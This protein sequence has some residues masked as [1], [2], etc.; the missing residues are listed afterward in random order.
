M[1]KNHWMNQNTNILIVDDN[2]PF[3]RTLKETIADSGYAAE[4]ALCG[5]EAIEQQKKNCYDLVFVDI[6]LPDMSGH[7]VVN[8]MTEICSTTEFI[9]VTGHSAID[10]AIEAVRQQRVL[11]YETKPL[12]PDRIL[13]TIRQFIERRQ[14]EK[15]LKEAELEI[16]KLSRAVEQ[17]PVSV[18]ITNIEGK[19]EYVNPRFTQLTG[20][21]RGEIIGESPKILQTGKTPPDVY[22]DLW[23]KITSGKEWRGEFCNKKKSGE[24]YYESAHISPMKGKDGNIS[25]Y[26]AIKE[27]ITDKKRMEETLIQSEKLKSLGIITAGISHE[28]NNIL[29]IISGNVQLLEMDHSDHSKLKGGFRSIMKAVDNGVLITDRMLEI[30]KSDKDTTKFVP[31]DINELLVQSIEFTKPR[32]K[33]MAQANGINYLID[34]KNMEDVPQLLCKPTEIRDVFINIINNALDAMP[35]GGNISFG[36]WSNEDTL[37]VSISDT[38]NGMS[39][40][41]RYHIFDPFFTTK[42]PEGTGLGMSIAF[43]TITRHG[44][45][46]EVESEWM[47]GSTFTLQ[48]PIANRKACPTST[49]EQGK[50]KKTLHILVVDDE[51][52]ICHMLDEFLSRN[53]HKVKIVNNG[54]DAL[55]IIKVEVFDLVL[56]DLAMPDVYGYDVINAVNNLEKRPKIGIITGWSDKLEPVDGKEPKVNFFLKKPF[57]LSELTKQIDIAFDADK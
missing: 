37:F 56:S 33:N 44:G 4:T 30:T 46:I 47:K 42:C 50:K 13:S 41:T 3:C 14:M 18:M 54:A 1:K 8:E 21:T 23:E 34:Q 16:Q 25:H 49:L 53:G 45:K 7:D 12:D 17:S 20:Y 38:G 9:Y 40:E 35:N 51:D 39:E 10:S 11:S 15:R 19:V 29:N 57:K 6:K 28:F 43:G 52:D 27:D 22:K 5:R 24:H 26:I 36:T 31:S 2:K 55:E 48:F 32:W